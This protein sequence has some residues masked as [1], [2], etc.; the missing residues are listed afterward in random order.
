MVKYVMAVFLFLFIFTRTNHHFEAKVRKIFATDKKI[1]TFFSVKE[2]IC[3]QI[4]YKGGQKATE[5]SSPDILQ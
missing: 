1:L 4:P 5:D 2:T 3:S